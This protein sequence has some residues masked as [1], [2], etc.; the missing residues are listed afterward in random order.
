MPYGSSLYELPDRIAIGYDGHRRKFIPVTEYN[1]KAVWPVAAFMA[2]AYTHLYHAAFTKKDKTSPLPLFAYTAVGWR[3]DNFWVCGIRVDK[4]IRQDAAHFNLELIEQGAQKFL[5]IFPENRLVRH[6]VDH[7]V[8]TYHCPAAQNMVM[9]RWE[10]PLPTSPSCNAACIGCISKQESGGIPVTQNRLTFVPPVE[11]IVELAVR[12][13]ETAPS[14]IVSFGQGCEGEPLL[15]GDIIEA[16]IRGIRKKTKKGTININTNASKP[17]IVERLNKAG[18]D[19]IR[20]SL[21]SAK[22]DF[23][24]LYFQPRGYD[25]PDVLASL[26]VMRRYK[27]WISL[28]YFIFPGLTDQPEEITSLIDI[29][30]KYR[31]DY[32]QMR[33]LNIDPDYYCEKLGLNGSTG[34]PVGML[35]WMEQIKKAVPWIRFGYYN[36]P[37]ENW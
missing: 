16:A 31:V 7:C 27:K 12:H 20:V 2:P 5:A 4:D 23:Y 1:G 6:L 37:K 36:P 24:N 21:N 15:Q 10:C 14:A 33:N 3:E 11:D 25:F 8:R 17:H 26:D 13:L 28:N 19:S 30:K 35:G 29:L 9:E 22:P 18:L 32:I 34:P